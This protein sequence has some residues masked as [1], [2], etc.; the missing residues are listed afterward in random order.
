MSLNT[1]NSSH[2]AY[3][4]IFLYLYLWRVR[5][6]RAKEKINNNRN[7]LTNC[8]VTLKYKNLTSDHGKARIQI[9]DRFTDTITA[10]NKDNVGPQILS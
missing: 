2:E 1:S 8:F 10:I 3:A 6:P 4:L 5:L 9:T 7:K